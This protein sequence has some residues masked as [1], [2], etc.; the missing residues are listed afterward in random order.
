MWSRDR[1]LSKDTKHAA[2]MESSRVEKGVGVGVCLTHSY[3]D[4]TPGAPLLCLDC[5]TLLQASEKQLAIAQQTVPEF[6]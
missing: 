1:R 5:E 4:K 2:K 3:Q 6:A